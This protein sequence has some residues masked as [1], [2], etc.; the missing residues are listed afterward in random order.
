MLISEDMLQPNILLDQSP[1]HCIKDVAV[2]WHGTK[3]AV[4]SNNCV[5]IW[6]M[7]N[8]QKWIKEDV[9]IELDKL[10]TVQKVS[11]AHPEFGQII[12][13]STVNEISIWEFAA[14]DCGGQWCNRTSPPLSEPRHL[15]IRDISFSPSYFGMGRSRAL[16][17][18]YCTDSGLLKIRRCKDA[19]LL[20][21]WETVKEICYVKDSFTCLAW[22]VTPSCSMIA[23]GTSDSS[24]NG[25]HGEVKL[26]QYDDFK[27]E[28][29]AGDYVTKSP[30]S[31][32][33]DVAF[34][35]NPGRSFHTLAI[36]GAEL[37]IID[38]K[39][40][41]HFKVKRVNQDRNK[42]DPEQ[43]RVEVWKLSWS[44]LGTT[45]CATGDDGLI[46]LWKNNN[47]WECTKTI[48]F[49]GMAV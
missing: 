23:V 5:I 44:S 9:G 16:D 38:F 10:K 18:A 27:N 14:T 35:P 39:V 11:W 15:L 20:K 7:N 26:F 22:N 33:H 46:R 2:N 1:S 19:R 31:Q 40:T 3:M 48:K 30:N 17:L 36:A 6:S 29:V 45:L 4:C 8:Q 13:V 21:D 32:I 47:R 24:A 42:V 12:A 41:D 37:E 49:N 25:T 43:N 28:W 34:A